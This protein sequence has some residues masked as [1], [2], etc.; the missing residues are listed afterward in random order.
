ML[1]HHIVGDNLIKICNV[2]FIHSCV[3]CCATQSKNNEQTLYSM[4]NG[5]LIVPKVTV[6]YFYF[7]MLPYV[8]LYV[9]RLESFY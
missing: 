1:L 4:Y 9:N 3:L 2:M 6:T 8:F 5:L 7:L